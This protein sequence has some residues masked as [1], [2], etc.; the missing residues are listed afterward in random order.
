MNAEEVAI[1]V[2]G[3]SK[4]YRLYARPVD[5]LLESL[6]GGAR[7]TERW[8]LQDISFQVARGEVVGVVGPNGAGKST[9]LKIIT[10][11]LDKTSGTVQI[12]GK[13]SAILELGSGFHPEYTG[14]ENI[15]MGGMCL[16]MSREEIEGKIPGIIAFSELGS[17]MD[18]PFKTYSSGMQARLT[19]ATAISVNPDIFIVDEAL[20][21]GDAYF[22][23]KCLQRVK[24]ICESGSTVFFVSHSTDLVRRLC[25]RAML[26]EGGRL[27]MIGS[28][29]DVC[30]HYDQKVLHAASERIGNVAT[31]TGDRIRTDTA[32]IIELSVLNAQG[33]RQNAFFQH[34]Q[35]D[36]RIGFRC[37]VELTN[38]AVWV[39]LMRTDGV[40][41]T[42]WLSHEPTMNRLGSFG[43]GAHTVTVKINDVMLGDGEFFLTVALF[44]EKQGAA[45]TFYADPYCMWD[46]TTSIQIKRRG[47]PLTT[48]Y[49]Q[50]MQLGE[51]THLNQK[52]A[53]RVAE[54]E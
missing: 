6:F 7:H 36:L 16:G 42:S 38:P 43:I 17:V 1:R 47:R 53:V 35:V 37:H 54:H 23:N 22:V 10:G 33:S 14:L 11:T 29:I 15:V 49:D 9:L 21:A 45:T 24:E 28:A 30:S 34:D 50:P 8:A 40:V 5:M 32:E 44:P 20:A 48:I 46:R 18:Q 12:N 19:F 3:V 51:T 27:V 31:E 2:E 13:I 39:R 4:S 26:I 25:T 41:A 52:A